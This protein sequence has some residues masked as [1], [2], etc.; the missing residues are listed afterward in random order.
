MFTNIE[1]EVLMNINGGDIVSLIAGGVATAVTVG[2]AIAV[3]PVAAATAAGAAI[4]AGASFV[5]GGLVYEAGEKNPRVN[6]TNPSEAKKLYDNG[7]WRK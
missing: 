4:V 1:S 5:T 6:F 7:Y 2:V 3:A